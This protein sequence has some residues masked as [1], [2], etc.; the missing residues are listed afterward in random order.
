[1]AQQVEIRMIGVVVFNVVMVLLGL[2]V[3]GSLVPPK[4]LS[5]MLAYLHATVGITTPAPEKVRMV[6]L[7]WIASL[8]V[9]VDGLLLLLVVLTSIAG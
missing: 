4:L 2:A 8:I 5:D 7:I 9:I 6:A 3:G 1:V